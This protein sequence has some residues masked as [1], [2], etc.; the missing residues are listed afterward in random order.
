MKNLNGIGPTMKG[1]IGPNIKK[2]PDEMSLNQKNLFDKM[3]EE[4]DIDNVI[5]RNEQ[6]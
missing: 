3:A 4:F 5:P 2:T 1:N 6:K